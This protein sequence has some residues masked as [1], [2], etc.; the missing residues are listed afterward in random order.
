M[1]PHMPHVLAPYGLWCYSNCWSRPTHTHTCMRNR[2]PHPR[3]QV[4]MEFGEKTEQTALTRSQGRQHT[5]QQP[6]YMEPAPYP[7]IFP[8]LFLPKSP[9]SIPFP[10]FGSSPKHP[11]KI[12]CSSKLLFPASHNKFL[13]PAVP[14]VLQRPL[15]LSHCDGCHPQTMGLVTLPWQPGKGLEKGII[16]VPHCHHSVVLLCVCGD[17]LFLPLPNKTY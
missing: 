16:Q 15:P 5:D 8:N 12:L 3:K 6:F 2:V 14:K 10:T 9:R 7:S 13:I 4:E 11:I 1:H 17:E